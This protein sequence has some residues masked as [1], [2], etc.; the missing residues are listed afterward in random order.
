MESKKIER[1]VKEKEEYP[2][3]MKS[4]KTE[5]VVFMTKKGEGFV[6]FEGDSFHQLG[7]YRDDWNMEKN[8]E[9]FQGTIELSN[10]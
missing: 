2:R 9:D 6:V 3:L 7:K 5:L 8:F 10:Q 4:T 1:E